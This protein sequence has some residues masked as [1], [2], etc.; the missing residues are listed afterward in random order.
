MRQPNPLP[1]D[2]PDSAAPVPD[3][4]TSGGDR[5]TAAN[6]TAALIAGRVLD[7]AYRPGESLREIPLAEDLGVSRST[8]REAL[9][10]LERDGVVRIEPHRGAS[11]TQLSPE[12]LIEIYQVRTVLLGLA[13]G[14]C[15]QRCTD[16]EVQALKRLH[17]RMVRAV[18]DLRPAAEGVHARLSAD[19][20]LTVIDV[21]GNRRLRDLLMSNQIARYTRLGLSSTARRRQSAAT[22]QAVIEAM[23]RRDSASAERLGRQ[24]VT[25]TLRHA[26]GQ[27]AGV[28]PD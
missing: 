22:W 23:D 21:A 4:R 18:D 19:M 17:Q 15:A 7:G 27:F 12:E 25:D 5:Q 8:I 28:L 1:V 24:L 26:L 2:Q 20:A 14:L 11:V 16:R 10:I 9:R 13:M 3:A 6:R